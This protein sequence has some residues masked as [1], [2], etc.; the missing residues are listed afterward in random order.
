MNRIIVILLL[1]LS[2][3]C[4]TSG[5][6]ELVNGQTLPQQLDAYILQYYE[7]TVSVCT[8]IH[9]K[10]VMNKSKVDCAVSGNT[11]HLSFP[12]VEF[13]N[14]PEIFTKIMQL[15][16]NWCAAAQ[17]K[18]GKTATWARHFRNEKMQAVRPCYKGDK[19]RALAFEL[20]ERKKTTE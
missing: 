18:T 19:L 1:A 20:R 2:V 11:M 8:E 14:Q 13:H 3:G 5:R 9:G 17:S 4:A 12:S 15:E 7:D 10:A 6:E 16:Y